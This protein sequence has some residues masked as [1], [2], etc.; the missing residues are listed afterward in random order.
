MTMENEEPSVV[1]TSDELISDIREASTRCKALLRDLS[2]GGNTNAAE[3]REQMESFNSW[4]ANMG[5]FDEGRESIVSRLKC[6]ADTSKLVKQIL[7]SLEYKLGNWNLSC[8][9]SLSE[10]KNL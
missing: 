5:V 9:P 4:V 6:V 2:K 8:L 7:L 1:L 3:A 10:K